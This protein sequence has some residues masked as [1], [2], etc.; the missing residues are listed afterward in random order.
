M[1]FRNTIEQAMRASDVRA[2]P[3]PLRL[4]LR[5]RGTTVLDDTGVVVSEC[6][7]PDVAALFVLQLNSGA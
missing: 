3:A 4:P 7:H 2:P 1:L 6:R 5:A